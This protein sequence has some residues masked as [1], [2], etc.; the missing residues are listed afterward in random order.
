VAL[1]Y[2]ESAPA[3]PGHAPGFASPEDYTQYL[4]ATLTCE[5]QLRLCSF[6]TAWRTG[7]PPALPPEVAVVVR[8]AMVGAA[9]DGPPG[10]AVLIFGR[11]S[12]VLR[13]DLKACARHDL[14][15]VQMGGQDRLLLRSLWRGVTPKGKMLCAAANEAAESWLQSCSPGGRLSTATVFASGAFASELVQIDSLRTFTECAEGKE[16]LGKLL[17]MGAQLPAAEDLQAAPEA[18]EDLELAALSSEQKA[19]ARQLASWAQPGG[20]SSQGPVLVRGVFGSGKSR[21]LAA[22]IVF[23]DRLLT[24]QRDSRRILLVCQTNVAVDAVLQ[25]LLAHH[26]WDNFARLGSFKSVHPAL[27]YR[28]VSL[29]T[30]RQAA[31]KDLS[32]ALEKRPPE[33][34]EALRAAV[35]R[36]VL[37]PRASVWRRRR[38]VA[39]TVAALDAAEHLGPDALHCPLVLVDEVTQLTEP[40]VFSA[41]TRAGAQQALLVGDPRQLPPRVLSTSLQ[42]SLLERLWEDG[43]ASARMELATQYRCHPVIAEL[44]G[45]LFYGGWLRSGVSAQDRDSGLGPGAPPL[46]V[47]ISE[48][49]EIRAGQSYRHDAEARLCAAWLRRATSCGRLRS[50]DF[51]VICLYRPQAE[52]CAQAAAAAGVKC[53][54]ATVDAFQGGEREAMALCCGRSSSTHDSFSGCPRRLNVALSRARRHLVI[55]GSEAFLSGH[56]IFRHVLAAARAHGCVH[57]A[58]DVTG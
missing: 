37:P 57:S 30:T 24:A 2:Q 46:A 55:F 8:G 1:V 27:L 39:A 9:K 56:Q 35:D 34:R 3:A 54:C 17:G 29:M 33:V 48:G 58:R 16:A 53:E 13:G 31:A 28:T 14:W 15:V 20:T 51:G 41:F 50:E 22:C 19:V 40:A 45:S 26:N 21:T 38:L 49:S 23:L 42:R 5:M 43:P 6:A 47:V 32:E 36:G 4:E 25:Q 10:A 44:G 11:K 12:N 7:G 18:A 52:A